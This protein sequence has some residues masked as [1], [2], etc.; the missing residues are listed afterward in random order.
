MK[1]LQINEAKNKNGLRLVLTAH[2]PGPWSEAAKAVNWHSI[3]TH[4]GV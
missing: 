3:L 2:V 4:I 1:Y